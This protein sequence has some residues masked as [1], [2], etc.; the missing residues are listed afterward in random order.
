MSRRGSV[1]G[2]GVVHGRG[3]HARKA[4]LPARARG[5]LPRGLP[6]GAEPVPGPARRARTVAVPRVPART[7]FR[8]AP[9]IFHWHYS[10]RFS[11]VAGVRDRAR[12][13]HRPGGHRP[14]PLWLA[15]SSGSCC[16]RCTCRSS[17]SASVLRLRLGVDAARGRLLRDL[18]RQQQRRAAAAVLIAL[19][20]L[21]F[22]LEFGAGLIKLRGD[23]CWR[24]LTCLYY[25]HETQPM[26]SPFSWYFHRLPKSLHRVEVAANHVIQLVVPFGLFL[27][28]PVAGTCAAI[29]IATQLCS[30]SVATSRGSTG[31]PS[32][33]RCRSSRTA[34]GGRSCPASPSISTPT[35]RCGG[36]S[37]GRA[38]RR[39]VVV[40]S[41][42]PVQNLLS[43]TQAM[44]AS[45][46]A[47]HLVNTYGAFG[48]ITRERFEIV[49][50]G[51]RTPTARPAG[52][53]TSSAA[54]PAIPAAGHASSRRT[55]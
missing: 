13:R 54:S 24:D 4:R 33:W 21:L 36:C 45:F 8:R 28:Q 18:P 49:I 11:A 1:E 20:W 10:D 46:N 55:T 12:G 53:S 15:M 51:T 14:A 50:E 47:W 19:R 44:N 6:V 42:R 34:S 25:H 40:L 35:R 41:W 5:D 43:R 29:M 38:P 22:R 17:T 27:P 26:P 32:C 9:S 39:L 52:T 48:S 30:S 3:L 16:G 23:A 37:S 2:R 7:S 31:W